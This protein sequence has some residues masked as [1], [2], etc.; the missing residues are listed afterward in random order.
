MD[1]KI[2]NNIYSRL[3]KYMKVCITNKIVFCISRYTKE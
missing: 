3:L 2:R 1:V